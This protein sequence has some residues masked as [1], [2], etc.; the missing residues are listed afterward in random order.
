MLD[1][2][3]GLSISGCIAGHSWIGM[4]YVATDYVPKISRALIGPARIFN[5]ALGIVTLVGL[6]TL[7]INDRGGMRGAIVGLWR[8]K[9]APSVDVEGGAGGE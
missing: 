8:P 9:I 4:N 7:S 2:A 6:G 5:A 3:L 1:K